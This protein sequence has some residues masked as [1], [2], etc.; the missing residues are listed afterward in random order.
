MAEGSVSIEPVLDGGQANTFAM[1]YAAGGV[2]FTLLALAAAAVL[3]NVPH[4]RLQF[5]PHA[6]IRWT[7]SLPGCFCLNFLVH[8]LNTL[9][10]AVLAGW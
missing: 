8:L 4:C 3:W 1:V 7:K 2:P 9:T 5:L 10:V 6:A